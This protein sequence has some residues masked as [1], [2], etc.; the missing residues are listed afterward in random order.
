MP[1]SARVQRV[2][3]E[4]LQLQSEWRSENTPAMQ[5][6]GVLVRT[7]MPGWLRDR[8]ASLVSLMPDGA[9]DLDVQGKDGTGLKAEIPWARVH[10]V[11]RSPSPF[12]G[13]YLVYL[14]SASGDRV[15][16]SLNQGTTTWA[17]GEF[18]PQPPTGLR[19]R[20]DWARS[21]LSRDIAALSDGVSAI[22][23]GAR[24]SN[25]G[26]AY[27]L[28]NVVALEYVAGG[29][30]APAVLEADLLRMGQVLGRLYEEE[31]RSLAVPGEPAPEVDDAMTAAERTASPRRR[32]RGYRLAA[33]ERVAVE[34]HAVELARE[35]LH[36]EGYRTKDV[37]ATESFDVDARR[38]KE[39][40][41]VEVKGTTSPGVEVILTK[42]EVE[43]HGREH[44]NTMLIVVHSIRLQRGQP[45]TT[46][47]G[48]VRVLPAWQPDAAD[49]TALSYRY[50]VPQ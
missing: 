43:L 22:V 25:L 17:N 18:R 40:I 44:P 39:R 16:L 26:P 2:I 27:Q 8:I 3:E 24:V 20:V 7:D 21:V 49:L 37:G 46:S 13:W 36:G 38:G 12:Q 5:R 14:F 33:A 32:G 41:F 1:Y 23:L 28:G 35:Y 45:P 50:A 34:Q 9:R 47:G 19:A 42:A 11:T 15:Y 30:P 31:A 10:S 48:I 6:R 4:I 29:V